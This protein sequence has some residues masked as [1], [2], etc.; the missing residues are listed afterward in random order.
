MSSPG[1]RF[2]A[3]IVHLLRR[4]KEEWLKQAFVL[5]KT[6]RTKSFSTLPTF[7]SHNFNAAVKSVLQRNLGKLDVF[8]YEMVYSLM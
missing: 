3:A 7:I 8:R 5:V 1:N 6:G 4:D 2:D